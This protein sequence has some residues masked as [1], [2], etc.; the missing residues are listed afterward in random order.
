MIGGLYK[1]TSRLAIAAAAG[2]FMGGLALTP[3]QAADL[4]GDC[5]ADLEE[6]VAE[7]EA[8]TV[9]KGNRKVS[10]TLYGHV[11]TALL[12]WDNG[13][14]N[15]I[16]VVDNNQSYSRV[17]VKGSAKAGSLTY[18]FHQ[19]VRWRTANSSSVHEGDDDA[20]EG[21]AVEL[22]HLYIKGGFGKVTLGK[23]AMPMAG[24]TEVDLSGTKVVATARG[25]RWNNSFSVMTSA[26]ATAGTWGG[27]Y[28]NRQG[29]MGN[30][31]RHGLRY[32]SPKIAGFVL[33]AA[34][35]E[36]DMW[37]VALR[38]A[39]AFGDIK[40]AA[41][42]GYRQHIAYDANTVNG[43]PEDCTSI[44]GRDRTCTFFAGSGAILHTP[45]GLNVHFATG[46]QDL[47]NAGVDDGSFYYIKGGI[48]Q[49]FFGPGKTALYGEYYSGRLENNTVTVT[50]V[51]D[52]FADSKVN[53]WGLG[54]VQNID[55]A[56][57]ELYVGY[58]NYGL[59]HGTTNFNDM[60]MVMGGMRI[61]F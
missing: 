15:D 57:T 3:A 23:T 17:G 30:T 26:G 19:Q 21:I 11:N 14:D 9:R 34:W 27:V 12:W 38:F 22:S 29:H 37:G 20:G 16:Y 13:V 46:T 35:G 41:G 4:G 56:A 24:I 55:A 31:R 10:V 44:A 7:L 8:T 5:C 47:D 1:T 42:I 61:K 49:N 52:V 25:G 40:V 36:D 51:G 48:T 6:R 33:S 28:V 59:S 50:G 45:T 53:F 32:D 18:G 2:L 58:R 54:L 60:S 43:D 39:Q